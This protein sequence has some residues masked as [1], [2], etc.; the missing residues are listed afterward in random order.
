MATP[1]HPIINN[2]KMPTVHTTTTQDEMYNAFPGIDQSLIIHGEVDVFQMFL[3]IRH[4]WECGQTHEY[5]AASVTQ[6]MLYLMM[7]LL[8]MP[9]SRTMHTHMR[10]IHGLR[11]HPH[12]HAMQIVQRKMN[13]AALMINER[14]R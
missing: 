6:N 5:P 1:R 8:W 14:T 11:C 12:V 4:L 13:A 10:T 9:T 2:A 7:A 3:V